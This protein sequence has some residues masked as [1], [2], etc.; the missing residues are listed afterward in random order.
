M[1][2]DYHAIYLAI[3]GALVI[4]VVGLLTLSSTDEP[5]E[6]L[7]HRVV[8]FPFHSMD[9]SS[10]YLATELTAKLI[11]SLENSQ[12]IDVVLESDLPPKSYRAENHHLWAKK[13][14]V[15]LIFEGAVQ[16]RGENARIT[17]Q[18]IDSLSDSHIWA[19][20]FES[21]SDDIN[22]VLTTIEDMILVLASR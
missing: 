6:S 7:S 3:I 21:R 12:I 15:K 1:S 19:Q 20:T 18:I 11:Q 14:F 2:K 9:S 10:D 8:I 13:A 4:V 17:A 5:G 22:G 16:S